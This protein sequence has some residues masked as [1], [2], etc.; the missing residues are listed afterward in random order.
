MLD[1][2]FQAPRFL[3]SPTADEAHVTTMDEAAAA[4]LVHRYVRMWFC[5][6]YTRY[7]LTRNGGSLK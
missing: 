4:A 3:L 5:L 1:I 2:M 7:I 6:I